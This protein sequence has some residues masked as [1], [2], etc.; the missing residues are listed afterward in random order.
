MT[1]EFAI[2]RRKVGEMDIPGGLVDVTDPCY[3][4]DVWCRMND[5]RVRP[6]KYN[7]YS[8]VGQEPHG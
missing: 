1:K 8:F 5:V 3:T 7:C 2:K 6:G 4:R